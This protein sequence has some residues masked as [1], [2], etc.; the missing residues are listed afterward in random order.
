MPAIFMWVAAPGPEPP[1]ALSGGMGRNFTQ[2]LGEAASDCWM[3]NGP[4]I[5]VP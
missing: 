4:H 5:G 3:L 1:A 2:F